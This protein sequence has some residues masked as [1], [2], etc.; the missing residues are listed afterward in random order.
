[1]DLIHITGKQPVAVQQKINEHLIFICIVSVCGILFQL[2]NVYNR[3]NCIL[4][5]NCPQI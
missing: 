3:L 1:M 4:C 5:V 2:F